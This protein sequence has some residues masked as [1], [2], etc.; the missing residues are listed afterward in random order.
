VPK[1]VLIVDELPRNA[2]GKVEKARIR[3]FVQSQ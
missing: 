1:Q 2:L 3:E